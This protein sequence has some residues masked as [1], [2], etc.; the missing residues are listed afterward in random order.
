MKQRY[1]FFTKFKFLV[2]LS[3]FILYSPS[4]YSQ[5]NDLAAKAE[6]L[7]YSNPDEAI[8]IAKHILK[9]SHGAEEKAKINVI[10]GKSYLA[11]GDYNQAAI[12]IFDNSNQLSNLSQLTLTKNYL[13]KAK[14]TRILYLDKQSQNYLFK[15]QETVSQLDKSTTQDSL[16]F[17]IVLENI[18]MKLDRRESQDAINTLNKTSLRFK[19]F[20]NAHPTERKKIYFSKETAFSNLSM[21]DSAFVYI[22]KIKNF[23]DSNEPNNLY[24]RAIF[25]SELGHLKLQEKEFSQSEEAFFIALKFA[26]ILDNPNLLVRINRELAINYLA[27]NQTNKHKVYNDEFFVLNKIVEEMDE[28]SI[29]TIYNLITEEQEVVVKN[30]EDLFIYYQYLTL[31]AIAIILIIG[32]FILMKS[33][34]RK[35]RLKEI[36]KYLE[37]SRNNSVSPKLVTKTKQKKIAIP[38][39]TEKALLSKLK[40]FE[41]S[42]KYLNKDMSLAMLSS[43]FE[44]NTKYLSEVINNHYHDN[45]NTFINKLRVEYIID[46][47][48]NESSYINYKISFLAEESGFSSHSSFA[49]VFKSIVGMTPATFIELLK[50]ERDNNKLK[51][52]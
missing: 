30:Q 45:F 7:I 48:K 14:L 20:L 8:K 38:E 39:E 25:Y 15:A 50:T 9:N 23:T 52:N 42:Q 46:K 13:L 3:L 35:K 22:E 24:E 29:N 1:S 19:E 44:T 26:E 28:K 31:A 18:Y 37:I 21:Y 36:I 27:T 5:E 40:R 51:D 33:E 43:Q 2:G 10:L 17:H 11:K 49:T 41:K 34:G 47:L 32:I 16:Q 12:S 4:F 6:E